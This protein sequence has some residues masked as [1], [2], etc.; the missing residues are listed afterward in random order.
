MRLNADL[1]ISNRKAPNKNSKNA[2]SQ[3]VITLGRKNRNENVSNNGIFD[4]SVYLMVNMVKENSHGTSYKVIDISREQQKTSHKNS[5]NVKIYDRFS[6]N[7]RLTLRFNEPEHD[8]LIS[9]ADPII[10]QTFLNV[11]KNSHHSESHSQQLS[12]LK[13]VKKTQIQKSINN[14]HKSKL[15]IDSRKNYPSKES[16]FPPNLKKLKIESLQMKKI[17]LR[18]CRLKHLMCLDL[19]GN[20]FKDIPVELTALQS[21]KELNLANNKIQSIPHRFCQNEHFCNQ[22]L[23]LN[24]EGN[25][26][27]ILPNNLTNFY[28]LVTLNLKN[29]FIKR[30]P[31]GL[32]QKMLKLR[33]LYLSGC[34][35]LESLPATFFDTPR[36]DSIHADGLSKIFRRIDYRN[37]ISGCH[38]EVT[39]DTTNDVPS[40]LD[41]SSRFIL[42][43]KLLWMIVKENENV[44]PSVIKQYLKT[45]VRCYCQS[46]CLPSSCLIKVLRYRFDDVM[47][48]VTRD[49]VSDVPNGT[50]NFECI[51]CSSKCKDSFI[52]SMN[53]SPN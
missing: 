21:L 53:L 40:L 14:Y 33:F 29:N 9:N 28:N 1:I 49:I 17:D 51:F 44:I 34:K 23:L 39:S 22:L 5:P 41:I 2:M 38:E 26:L 20:V 25:S 45:L 11:L 4:Q 16:G 46:I 10:L 24:L 32:F 18:I 37:Y 42:K 35:Y 13:P 15:N 36:L 3:A 30:L 6:K 12:E 52:K 27:T 47:K 8:L 48:L 19:S 50:T 7:G 43:H 31:I